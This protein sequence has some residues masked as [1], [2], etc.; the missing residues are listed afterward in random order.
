MLS[1]MIMQPGPVQFHDD[2]KPTD[3]LLTEQAVNGDKKA[4]EQLVRKYRESIFSMVYFRTQS[5]MDA[6]D[7]TQDIFMNAYGSISRLKDSSLFKTWLYRIAV[8]K[9]NDPRL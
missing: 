5:R 2:I 6:E 7:L 1:W 9:L 3:N 4:F 8:N